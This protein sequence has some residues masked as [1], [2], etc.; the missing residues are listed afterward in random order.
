VVEEVLYLMADG[1]QRVRRRLKSKYSWVLV[2]H[3][4]NPGYLAG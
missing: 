4:C 2:A 3:T 1:M